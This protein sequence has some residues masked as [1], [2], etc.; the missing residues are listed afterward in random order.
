MLHAECMKNIS[1]AQINEVGSAVAE[2]AS[3]EFGAQAPGGTDRLVVPRGLDISKM[4][5]VR[6]DPRLQGSYLIPVGTNV[7]ALAQSKVAYGLK[8]GGAIRPAVVTSRSQGEYL[9]VTYLDG[10]ADILNP[11]EPTLTDFQASLCKKIL[12]LQDP[13]VGRDHADGVGVGSEFGHQQLGLAGVRKP[14]LLQGFHAVHDWAASDTG[15]ADMVTS[16]ELAVYDVHLA[17]GAVRQVRERS[18]WLNGGVLVYNET[19]ALTDRKLS[20]LEPQ[21][22]A[23]GLGVVAL[24]S[25]LEVGS[26]SDMLMNTL[27]QL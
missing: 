24:A 19:M 8:V 11:Y 2:R 13:S 25:Q 14:N 1:I 5:G 23:L 4:N 16:E 22:F 9:H 12:N 17:S 6:T 26:A 27:R 7:A 15:I 10:P 18:M 21:E 3:R 20:V